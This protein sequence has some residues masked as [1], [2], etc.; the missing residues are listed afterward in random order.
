MPSAGL[1]VDAPED[2]DAAWASGISDETFQRLL[3]WCGAFLAGVLVLGG[4]VAA[5][6]WAQAGDS[7]S[8]R[9]N[10]VDLGFLQDMIDHHE[11]ALL[12][13]RTYLDAN[14]QGLAA[15]YAREVVMYQQWEI[16]RMENWLAKFGL[17]RGLPARR[18]MVWMGMDVTVATMPGMQT[19]ARIDELARASGRDAD[20]IWFEIM[21]DHHQGGA[22]MA[23]YAATFG[24]RKDI[25]KFADKMAYNQSI[26]IDEYNKAEARLGLTG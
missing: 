1:D 2:E 14:P 16:T 12:I 22:H 17:S 11:Q 9:P 25:T 15:P 7:R 26:E 6:A 19:Q 21:K 18:A 23:S 4:F 3:R 20:L 24:A 10:A 5:G 13:S 8:A